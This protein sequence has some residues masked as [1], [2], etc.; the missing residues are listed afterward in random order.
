MGDFDYF[1][2][3]TLAILSVNKQTYSETFIQAHRKLPFNI[4]YYYD[5]MTVPKLEGNPDLARFTIAERIKKRFKREFTHYE[6]ALI[7]SLKSEKVDCVLAEY[8]PTAC[9]NFNVIKHLKLPLLVHFHGYDASMKSVIEKY[10]DQYKDVFSYADAVIAVS[11][12]MK[13]NLKKL[14]CPEDKLIISTYGPNRDFL[15]VNPSYYSNQFIAVGRFVEKKAPNLTIQAFKRVVQVFPDAKLKMAGDG[16]LL[17]TCKNL[18]KA[19]QLDKN[20]EF[21]G[22]LTPDDIQSLFLESM[23]FV[24]HSITAESGDSEGT[25]VAVLEAQAAALPVISTYHAGIPDVVISNETG[26]LVE[27]NDVDGM[28]KMMMRI[29]EEHGLAQRLGMAARKR[30][31]EN[32]TLQR[33]LNDLQ[34]QI[35]NLISKNN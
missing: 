18:V 9:H 23:A 28:A 33:H 10:R 1:R 29:I 25:P 3:K 4:K 35:E 17:E 16:P 13:D 14:G 6:H 22:V 8:G 12:K 26:L 5:C 21:V 15:T 31:I 7:K 20:I 2:M 19:L 24:Q 11:K 30:I 34:K 27:E 32:F